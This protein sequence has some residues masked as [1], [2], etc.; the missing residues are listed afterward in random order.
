[1]QGY[2]FP[3]KKDRE[4]LKGIALTLEAGSFVSLVGTSGC[5]KEHHR[6]AFEREKQRDIRAVFNLA[7][8][9]FPGFRKES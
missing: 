5:G 6:G 4:I 1:M 9:S 8:Q 3:M 7:E 2:I